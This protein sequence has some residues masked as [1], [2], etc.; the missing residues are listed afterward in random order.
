MHSK[1]ISRFEKVHEY[2]K[3]CSCKMNKIIKEIEKI[4]K[5]SKNRNQENKSQ[6]L[7]EVSQNRLEASRSFKNR[8]GTLC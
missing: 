3:K 2:E 8:V 4:E 6:K 7:L 1:F 5:N